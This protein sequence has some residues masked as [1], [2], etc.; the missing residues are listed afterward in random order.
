M[1]VVRARRAGAVLAFAALLP[2]S[3]VAGVLPA[4]PGQDEQPCLVCHAEIGIRSSAGMPVYVAPASFAASVHGRAG[5]GC[6]G[7][8]A[9]LAKTEDFPHAP[10]LAAVACAR[11][12]PVYGPPSP[13][14]VHGTRSPRLAAKPVLCK[15]CHGYHDL[16][17]SSDPGSSVHASI[18]PA[19]CGKCHG[20]AGPNFAKGRVHELESTSRRSPSG[21]IRFLYKILIGVVAALYCF[22]I[23]TDLI[24]RKGE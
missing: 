5:I 12:H 6:T 20:G 17:P 19:T 10:D 13:A 18:R 3:A 16:L 15:D 2:A 21:F 4:S 9:D 7:C 22:Y 8:H 11:C 14:G 23:A 24:R 1:G